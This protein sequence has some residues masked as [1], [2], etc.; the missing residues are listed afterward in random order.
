M[1][2]ISAHARLSNVIMELGY[3]TLELD[4]IEHESAANVAACQAKLI[5]IR[6]KINT[7]LNALTATELQ[8]DF[9]GIVADSLEGLFNGR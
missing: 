9:A 5:A 7:E 4:K 3:V 6:D 1:S 2:R 8:S